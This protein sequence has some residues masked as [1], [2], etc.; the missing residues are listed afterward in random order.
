MDV[1]TNSG[2]TAVELLN[3]VPGERDEGLKEEEM[4]LAG[5]EVWWIMKGN[6]GVIRGLINEESGICLLKYNRMLF[7]VGEN[8]IP[9]ME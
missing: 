6:G 1:K 9:K 8:G 3:G 2:I 7:V 5:S 4:A